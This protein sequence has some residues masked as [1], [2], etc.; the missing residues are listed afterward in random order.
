MEFVDHHT[1]GPRADLDT[2]EPHGDARQCADHKADED[3]DLVEFYN[4]LV[5]KILLNPL[6]QINT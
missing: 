5:Y 3:E 6:K 1:D 4:F 2:G